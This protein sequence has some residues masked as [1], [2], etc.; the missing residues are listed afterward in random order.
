M[1]PLTTDMNATV[2]RAISLVSEAILTIRA[3]RRRAIYALGCLA[4]SDE[5]GGEIGIDHSLP[6]L[7]FQLDHRL[8]IL[9]ASIVD[10]NINLD[11]VSP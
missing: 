1:P 8:A 10:Q 4:A 5:G 6:V 2:A 11:A 9:N 3:P 7:E